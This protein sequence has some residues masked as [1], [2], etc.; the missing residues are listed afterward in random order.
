MGIILTL[1]AKV[2]PGIDQEK[3]YHHLTGLFICL[4]SSISTGH[5]GPFQAGGFGK[6]IAGRWTVDPLQERWFMEVY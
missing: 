5:W 4:P 3:S 1:S 2:G 6:P